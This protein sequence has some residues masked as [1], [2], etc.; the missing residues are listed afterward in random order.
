MLFI[1]F[2]LRRCLLLKGLCSKLGD[3]IGT[4]CGKAKSLWLIKASY[5]PTITFTGAA[6]TVLLRNTASVT[7]E[8][9][10][11]HWLCWE[12]LKK[13]KHTVHSLE[14]HFRKANTW[15]SSLNAQ[16]ICLDVGFGEGGDLVG[17]EN[18]SP[19]LGAWSWSQ[20][21]FSGIS[22]PT[23][24]LILVLFFYFVLQKSQSLAG[25]APP[26]WGWGSPSKSP[27]A[28]HRLWSLA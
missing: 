26:H 11:H 3:K 23:C 1:Y 28:P 12:T 14:K 22:Q 18:L 2:I 9:Q 13:M 25:W 5:H 15:K 7:G 20:S 27:K 17:G 6:N 8:K 21:L 16:T 24:W 10:T 4:F 19:P